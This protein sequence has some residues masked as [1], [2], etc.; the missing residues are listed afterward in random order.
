MFALAY[1]ISGR[2]GLLASGALLVLVL[3]IG[4]LSLSRP[5]SNCSPLEEANPKFW[6]KINTMAQ[7]AGIKKFKVYL[8]DDYIPNAYSYRKNVVLSL[9]LFEILGEEEILAITAHELGHI[10]NR[11]TVLFPLMAYLRVFSFLMP[12]LILVLSWNALYSFISFLT[13]LWYEFERSAFLKAREF[14]ADDVAIKVLNVPLS[15]KR[16]LEELKYYEDLM[17]KVKNQALPGIEPMIERR[18]PERSYWRP[19]FVLFPTHPSYDDR[20][21]RIVAFLENNELVGI[22]KADVN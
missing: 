12:P 4:L 8:L 9:G 7:L 19:S 13:Y 11:D 15:L 22:H 18:T 6:S 10:K 5:C 16:A 3:L 17:S 2:I 20:I 1:F 21:F 14:K